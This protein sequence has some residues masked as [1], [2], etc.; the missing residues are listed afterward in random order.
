MA[1]L[2]TEYQL[3]KIIFDIRVKVFIKSEVP[4][5]R[6]NVKILTVINYFKRREL[7]YVFIYLGDFL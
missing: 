5:Y 7:G 3:D 6:H 1:P 2:Q 4:I